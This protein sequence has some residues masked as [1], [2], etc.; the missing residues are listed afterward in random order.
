LD[1]TEPNAIHDA[2]VLAVSGGIDEATGTPVVCLT[3]RPVT[4]RGWGCLN[5]A[6]SVGNADALIGRLYAA[7]GKPWVNPHSGVDQNAP[8]G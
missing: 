1:R 5:Y 7:L 2:E 8:D 6:L 4:G 3:L